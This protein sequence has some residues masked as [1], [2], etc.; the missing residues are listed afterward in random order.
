MYRSYTADEYREH[1][2]LPKS[3]IVRG[4]L[5][6]G[7]YKKYPLEMLRASLARLGYDA[8][9]SNPKFDFLNP[10]QEFVIDNK[11]YWFATT[12][13]GAMLSEYLHLACLFGSKTNIL[14]GSCGGLKSGA[15]SRDIIVPTWS[16]AEESSA[17]AYERD[18]NNKYAADSALSDR[19]GEELGKEFTVH[20]GPTV[21]FQAM[22]G[23][24][25]ED[26]QKWNQDGFVGVEMEAATV[27]ATSNHFGASSAAILRIGDNLIEKETVLDKE[28]QDGRELR[29]AATER[30][31]DYA[32]K[33]IVR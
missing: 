2:E 12:Y 13:G 18:S 27:F 6:F 22:M 17:K 28:F 11:I 24:T 23:E 10:I 1:F 33:E 26:V 8:Q 14:L 21:T 4:F 31:F 19:L 30:T 3:Y 9:F 16:Y 29:R 20:R 7:T 32:L 5:V 25:W 15:K